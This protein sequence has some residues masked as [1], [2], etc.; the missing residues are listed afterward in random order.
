M[1]TPD[2]ITLADDIAR[3]ICLLQVA[4]DEHAP[5]HLAARQGLAHLASVLWEHGLLDELITYAAYE[6]TLDR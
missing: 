3:D 5:D 4:V 2:A 1:T 6:M